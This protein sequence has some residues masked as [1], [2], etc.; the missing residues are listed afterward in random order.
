[1]KNAAFAQVVAA[2][3]MF[4]LQRSIAIEVEG[5]PQRGIGRRGTRDEV[6]LFEQD[7]RSNRCRRRLM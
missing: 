4:L 2:E 7:A 1:M 3:S 6:W 5:A